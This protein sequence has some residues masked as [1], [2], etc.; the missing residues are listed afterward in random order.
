MRYRSIAPAFAL[1]A[2]LVVTG[3]GR[4]D[5]AGTYDTVSPATETTTPGAAGTAPGSY[6]PAM[7]P[8]MTTD[9]AWG[10]DT[11]GAGA[12]GMGTSGTTPPRP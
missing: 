8:G 2:A 12:G 9:T 1:T 3:C 4:D 10:A 7:Q 11:V 5:T 6:D